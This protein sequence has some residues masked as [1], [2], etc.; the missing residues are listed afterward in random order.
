MK[1]ILFAFAIF[2]AMLFP[3]LSQAAE[4]L[5]DTDKDGLVDNLELKF[6]TD[7]NNPDTDG[8]GF[9]DGLEIAKGF[10]PLSKEDKKLTKNILVNLK[11]QELYQQLNGITIRTHTVSTGKATMPTPKGTFTI[12]NKSV[13]AWSKTYGLWMPYWM[14][15]RGT[16]AG[17]HE[18][19]EWPNGYK[20]GANH[21]GRPVSHGCIRLD[22]TAAKIV[23]DWTDVGTKV[24]IN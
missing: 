7:I 14:G 8:D 2:L 19:P 17:I 9:V 21:L 4:P 18:L 24:V 16:R 23:Y 11:K 12:A 10:D 5:I 13:R 1:K 22:V 20:E 15:I 6:K 3:I